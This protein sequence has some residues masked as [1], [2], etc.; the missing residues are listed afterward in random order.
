VQSEPKDGTPDNEHLHHHG[1]I[2][3]DGTGLFDNVWGQVAG[4]DSELTGF[5][6]AYPIPGFT[7]AFGPPASAGRATT[8]DAGGASSGAGGT[9]ESTLPSGAASRSGLVII[10]DYDSTITSLSTSN[11]SLY[12]EITGAVTAAIDYYETAITNP[13][14]ITIGF[15]YG[16]VDGL[17]LGR[18]DLGASLPGGIHDPAN[19]YT[20]SELRPLLE[21]HD[22]SAGASALPAGDPLSGSSSNPVWFIDDSE[23]LALGITPDILGDD[24][25][26]GLSSSSSFT[27]NPGARAVSGEYDAIGVLEHEISEVMGRFAYYPSDGDYNPSPGD[28]VYSPL[29]LFRYTSAGALATT[30]GPAY[31][32]IDGGSNAN[33]DWFNSYLANQGDAGD[34]SSS[35]STNVVADSYDAFSGT[36]TAYTVSPTDLN[37]MEMLGYTLAAPCYAAGTRILTARGEVRVEDLAAG[38]MVQARFAGL[39]PIKWIGHRR[40]DCRRHPD[41]QQVWP[42]RV[43]AGAFGPDQPCRDLFLSPDHAVAVDGALIPIRLLM[44]GASIRQETG[45]PLVHYFHIELDRHDLLLADGTQAESYLDTGNRG[46]FANADAPLVLHPRLADPAAQQQR[47]AMSCLKLRCDPAYV[48]P[49]WRAL[50]ARAERL[51]FTLPV[52]ATTQDP[53]LCIVAGARR[54]APV[55]RNGGRYTFVLPALPSGSRLWSHCAVP[56]ALRPWLEDRRRLGVMVHRILLRRGTELVDVALDDPS[57]T[58]GWWAAERDAAVLWRWTDGDAA[59][60]PTDDVAVVDVLIGE[61]LPYPITEPACAGPMAGGH[62]AAPAADAGNLGSTTSAA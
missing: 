1:T 61:T 45:V 3:V 17:S 56:S 50:A 55:L 27:Y 58:D 46:M 6:G 19:Y 5:G 60:P 26:I 7:P 2:A 10:P 62:L 15:G 59:L 35:G 49:V 21:N 24:G 22:T 18:T 11:P 54:F 34:W 41:P 53:G 23:L 28:G 57:L 9:I 13:M 40:I 39:T 43:V 47:E 25:Y 37:V 52:V 38:D 36:G 8:I 20:Y 14:T 12:S 48:E 30:G 33:P 44:N 32:S 42:V 16:E 51:G 31:F 29:D 4:F